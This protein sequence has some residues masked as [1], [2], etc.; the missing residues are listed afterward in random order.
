MKKIAT[1]L[2]LTF[3]LSFIW[4]TA[5]AF[6]Y[7]PHFFGIKDFLMVHFWASGGDVLLVLII[8]FS[9]FLFF[10]W[11]FKEKKE[12]KMEFLF[13]ALIG[14]GLAVFVEKYALKTNRWAYG[15]WMPII[16]FLNVGLTPILQMILIPEIVFIFWK[17]KSKEF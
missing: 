16:P 11:F 9:E 2:I 3:S 14:F 6:L 13:I 8:L 5:Q 1:I 12:Q 15:P 7:A 17:K 4:E 10:R